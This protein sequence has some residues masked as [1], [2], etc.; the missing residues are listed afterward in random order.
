VGPN[1]ERCIDPKTL[2]EGLMISAFKSR[3][4]GFGHQTFSEEEIVRINLHRQGNTYVDSEAAKEVLGSDQKDDNPFVQGDNPFVRYLLI[5][6]YKEGYWSSAHMAVQFENVVDCCVALYGDIFDFL[7]IFDHS[8]GH[9]RKPAGS[10]LDA[11]VLNVGY[12]GSQPVQNPSL[13][14]GVEG[15][16]GDHAQQLQVGDTQHFIFQDGDTGPYFLTEAQRNEKKFD[17]PT[18]RL[19]SKKKTKKELA[20][21]LV[22]LG[23]VDVHNVPSW[24]AELQEK[25][26][27]HNIDLKVSVPLIVEGWMGKAKGLNQIAWERG[28][29]DPLETYTKAD[30]VELLL[31][32][33]DFDNAET[34]LQMIARNLG[35]V[36]ER[37]PKFH[38]EMAGEGIEYDWGFCKGKYRRQPIARKRGRTT[39][40]DLVKEVTGWAFGVTMN[41]CRRS[42]ARA[43]AYISAYYNIHYDNSSLT[44]AN[45]E[46][47]LTV[48]V[49]GA[50]A[51]AEPWMPAVGEVI[52]MDLIE[53]TK[54]EYQ[55]HRG[56]NSFEK[57]MHV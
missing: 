52:S 48:V 39:F 56:V 14:A 38:C 57:G 7:F 26:N 30:L 40:M 33:S 11:K 46:G 17:T 22:S 51:T 24:L 4:L 2:G 3:D 42:S 13:I 20:T 18:G 50:A 37:T 23:L 10:S 32:C 54:K 44:N 6:K 43:R 35:V 36:A 27:Q 28:L 41:Q 9:D 21:E 8:S 16:L 45:D 47:G 5:G 31:K 19:L 34:N 53:K 49:E 55:S 25:A 1:G 12:G 15:F 29:I